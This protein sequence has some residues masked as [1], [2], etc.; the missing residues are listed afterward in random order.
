MGFM[1]S[2]NGPELN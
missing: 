1:V 2:E